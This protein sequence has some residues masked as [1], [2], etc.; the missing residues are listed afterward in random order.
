MPLPATAIDSPLLMHDPS[1]KTVM[2]GLRNSLVLVALT[3]RCWGGGCGSVNTLKQWVRDVSTRKGFRVWVVISVSGSVLAP[4]SIGAGQ[5]KNSGG[6]GMEG[7]H[8]SLIELR[9]DF[10]LSMHLLG[11]LHVPVVSFLIL[12]HLGTYIFCSSCGFLGRLVLWT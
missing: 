6:W 12:L 4:V 2:G 5:M 7:F 10:A 3:V 1:V 9:R 8:L 11:C